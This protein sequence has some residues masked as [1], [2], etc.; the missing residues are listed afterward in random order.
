MII[1]MFNICLI[2]YIYMHMYITIIMMQV[3]EIYP[4]ILYVTACMCLKKVK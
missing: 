3:L 4:S 2:N 1:L